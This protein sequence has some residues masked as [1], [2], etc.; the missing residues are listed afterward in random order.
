MKRFLTVLTVFL[1]AASLSGADLEKLGPGLY[2][3]METSRGDMVFEL[4]YTNAPL[5]V[6]SFAGLAEGTIDREV[7][8]DVP[9]YGGLKFYRDIDR[10]AIFSGDPLNNGLGGPGYTIPR[11]TSPRFTAGEAGTLVMTGMPTESNGSAFFITKGRGDSFLDSIYT[12][13]GSL[14]QGEK[15]LNRLE[16]RDE[17]TG[18][19]I[20]KKGAEAEAFS[21]GQEAFLDRYEAARERELNALAQ[22]QPEV[23][24]VVRGLADYKKSLS[25][26]YY[27]VVYEGFG[28]TPKM[29]ETA[30]VHY[31]GSLP[32]GTVFDSSL[33]RGQPFPIKIGTDS[34]IPGWLESILTMKTGEVRTVVIPP[35]LAYGEREVG[36]VIPAN[37]WLVFSIQ[38]LSIE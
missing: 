8:R 5:T 30:T 13:F 17:L 3:V 31:T 27:H 35:E 14:V 10:Y 1:A 26:L 23:A 22:T 19:T 34:V 32:D 7:R 37:S 6:T 36:G 20:V 28:E 25:G 4:D 15:V 11:E 9:F 38:L 18:V 16:A 33:E 29:G 2:A 12:P 24:S 21:L